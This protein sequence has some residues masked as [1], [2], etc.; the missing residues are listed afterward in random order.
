MLRSQLAISMSLPPSQSSFIFF[1]E[2]DAEH[3]LN[4]KV[5]EIIPKNLCG[6]PHGLCD[7]I[8]KRRNTYNCIELQHRYG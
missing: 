8:Q 3:V 1:G 5:Q 4:S 6:V 7:G 2:C